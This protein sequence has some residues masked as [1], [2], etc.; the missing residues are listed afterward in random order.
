MESNKVNVIIDDAINNHSNVIEI[1]GNYIY[2][3]S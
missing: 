3:L 2:E 1:S